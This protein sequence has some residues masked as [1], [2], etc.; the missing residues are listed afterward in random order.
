MVS[1]FYAGQNRPP[2]YH[3]CCKAL[4]LSLQ[5]GAAGLQS[6]IALLKHADRYSAQRLGPVGRDLYGQGKRNLA[7][8]YEEIQG[9][10][11]SYL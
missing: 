5:G 4:S 3:C 8:F 11:T 1:V 7:G 9:R 10:E 6:C 2:V